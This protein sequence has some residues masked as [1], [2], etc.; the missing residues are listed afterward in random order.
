MS[1]SFIGNSWSQTGDNINGE[2]SYDYSGSSVSLSSDGS[3][4]AIGAYGNDGDGDYNFSGHTRIYQYSSG[5]WSQ[6]GNDIDGESSYDYS[7]LSVSLS[8]DGSIVA[9]GAY[10]DD[11]NGSNSGHTRIYQYSSG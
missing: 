3:I 7:G 11:E 1:N 2:S 6:L 8:D 5:S 4:V 9:I 10:G